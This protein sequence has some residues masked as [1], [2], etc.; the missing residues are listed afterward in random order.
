MGNKRL[1]KTKI[2][3]GLQCEKR[4]FLEIHHPELAEISDETEKRMA[5]G[6]DVGQVAR[7]LLPG[8]ILIDTKGDLGLALQKTSNLLSGSK[9]VTLFE[10]TFEHKGVLVK[11]DIFH[12]GRNSKRLVEVKSSTSVKAYHAQ[13][14]AIQ[15]WVMK[16]AGCEPEKAELSHINN[17]FVYP[18]NGNYRGLFSQVDMTDEVRRMQ[19]EVG[20]WVRNLQEVL[21]GDMPDIHPGDQ[22]KDPFECPFFNYCSAGM[23]NPEYPVTLLPWGATIAKKLLEMGIEDLRQAREDQLANPL[24]RKIW[25]ATMSGK[26]AIDPIVSKE[27]RN[28][29]YPRYYLDFE[30]IQFAVPVW[31]GTRPYLQIPF[32]YSCHIE[33]EDGS[34]VHKEYLETSGD[35]PVKSLA[36]NL[37]ATVGA[38]GPIY[39][40]GSFEGTVLNG[41][42]E[43]LPRLAPKLRK[44]QSR[45][46]DLLS[47]ARRVYYH[48]E[49]KGSWSIKAVLPTIAPELKYDDLEVQHGGMAQEAYLEA[50]DDAT[51]AE[52]HTEIRKNLLD[53]CGRDTEKLIAIARFFAQADSY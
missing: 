30:T 21:E 35:L 53:F 46:V 18:G 51:T 33:N 49:M 52:R 31:A 27:I 25:S 4:L 24:H 41:L 29:A 23:P 50:I 42:S 10:A 15:Y 34:I 26:P 5:Q 20:K 1:S 14:V 32:Q 48:P 43:M 22:C 8:G 38:E 12:A 47:I 2:M 40:Y 44:I 3:S 6:N 28:H 45:L 37:I 7:D 16:G 19:R 11:T 17:S 9:K 36:E 13:D 39:A